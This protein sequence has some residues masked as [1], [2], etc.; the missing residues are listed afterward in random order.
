MGPFK[1]QICSSSVSGA[2]D[3]SLVLLKERD[4]SALLS[5]LLLAVL[6]DVFIGIGSRA[7]SKDSCDQWHTSQ[8]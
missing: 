8:K 6:L 7:C 1:S 2:H 5:H 3:R 4:I